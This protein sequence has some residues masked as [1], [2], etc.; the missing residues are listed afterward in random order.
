L[1]FGAFPGSNEA[2]V[3]VTGVATIGASAKVEAFIMRA[4][5]ADHTPND[6]SY[7]AMFCGLTCGDVVASTGFTI[8]ARSEQKLT[9]TFTVQYVWA[10]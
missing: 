3:T 7:A 10:D 6:H 5:T 1:D 2:S 9:G 4:T 8:Y